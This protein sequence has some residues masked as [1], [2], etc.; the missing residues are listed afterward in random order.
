MSRVTVRQSAD[1]PVPTEIM[2]E[3]IVAISASMKKLR[4]SRLNDD[5]LFLLIQHA[6]PSSGRRGSRTKV[7]IA[8]IKAVF[9][10]IS[11]LEATFLKKRAVS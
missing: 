11:S 6:V 5:A 7:S 3:S 9:A 2:A 4:A 8:N 1:N 10:G